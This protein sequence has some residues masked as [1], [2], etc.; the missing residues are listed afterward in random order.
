[1]LQK[2]P[3]RQ[4]LDLSSF[5]SVRAFVAEFQRKKLPLHVLINNAGVVNKALR[6]TEDGFEETF[7]VNH[8]SHFLLTNLLIDNLAQSPPSRVV[9]VSSRMHS[10]SKFSFDLSDINYHGRAAQFNGQRAYCNSKLA[11]IWFSYYFDSLFAEKGI[12]SNALT[13]GFIPTTSITRSY[14]PTAQFVYKSILSRLPFCSTEEKGGEAIAH[15]ATSADL[16]D[17]GGKFFYLGQEMASSRESHDWEKMK[18][19][20]DLSLK[21][22]QLV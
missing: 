12:R 9:V 16:Q 6:L 14:S 4:C 3:W 8:L 13:P 17:T 15:L 7:Q 10:L 1:M 2:R 18:K 5:K 19:L 20:W 22:T 11:N 21:W